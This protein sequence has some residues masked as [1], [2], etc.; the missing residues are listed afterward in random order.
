M[1]K[2]DMHMQVHMH[3]DGMKLRKLLIVIVLMFMITHGVRLF[4]NFESCK[5]GTPPTFYVGPG[6]TYTRIQDALN[7]ITADGYRIF[8]YNGTYYESLII[9]YQIDLFGED[10]GNTIIDGNGSNTVITVN[11]NNVNIS[12]FTIKNRNASVNSSLIHINGD[13]S[14]ITD[15]ILSKGYHGVLL[16]NSNNHLIYDNIIRDNA[17]DGIRLNQSNDNVNISYNTILRNKNGITSYSSQ[18]NRIYNNEIMNNNQNGI[19]LNRTCQNNIIIDN[20]ASKNG[21][22]GIYLNDYSNHQTITS[23]EIYYNNN[24]GLVL[25]N[26]STNY[27]IND[28]K[29]IGNM[30][31]GMMIIGSTNNISGNIISSNRK[32][33]LYLSADDNNT[34]YQN[35]ISFN[36]IAG[37]R[38]YNTTHDIIRNNE[39]FNNGAYGAYL[40]FFTMNNLIYNNYFHDNI[41]N[42]IDKSL[43]HNKWNVTKITKLNIIGGP[44]ICGNYWDDYDEISEDA[45]DNDTDG[46]AD[47]PYM[48]YGLNIDSGPL[49]DTIRPSIESVSISP[50]IQ[51]LGKLT[52]LSVVVTDNTKVK[53]VYLNIIDPNGLG[54][55]LSITQ[56]KTGDTYFYNTRFSP[57]GNYTV[58]ITAKDSRNW[59]HSSKYNFSI[60]PGNPPTIVDHSPTSGQPSAKFIFNTTVTS[61]DA[62]PSDLRV[63]V[64]W[65]HGDKGGNVSLVNT[66]GSYFI[67]TIVLA[68]SIAN[69]TYHFYATDQWGNDVQTENKKVKINDITPPVILI[70]QHGPS[71]EDLPNSYTFSA[72]ITD[73]SAVSSVTIEYWYTNHSK[74]KVSMDAMGNNSY[75]KVII[76]EENPEKIFCIINAS[77]IAGNTKDTKNPVACQY[78]PY[79]GMV[80]QEIKLNGTGS[81]DLDGTISNYSWN[82]GD[83]TTGRGSTVTHTY[84]SNGNY[85]VTLTVIDNDGNNGT[86]KTSIHIISFVQHKI[87]N[88][89]L[90]LINSLY[91]I[92]LTEQVFCYD[93]DGNGIED[94]FVDPNRILTAV[95][96]RP[97]NLNGDIAFLLSI[98]NDSIPEF[99]WDTTNDLVFSISHD[100]GVVTNLIVDDPHQQAVMYV[101]VNKAQWIYFEVKD[102]YPGSP[103]MITSRARTLSSD[104]F[105]REQQKIYVFDDPET[106]YQF[107]YDSIFPP[108]TA[109]FSP[110][111]G[112]VINGDNPTI[113]ITYN[114][115]VTIISATFNA[116][117]IKSEL[118]SVDNRNFTFT[119][120]GY[121][122]N[123]SYALEID[124]Q[125]LQGT[126]YLSSTVVYF[127]LAYELPPQKSFL[128]KNGV[129]ILLGGF[130]GALGALLMFFKVKNVTVDGFVYLKNRKIIPFFK[131]I[132]IGPIS[133]RIPDK[134]LSKAEFYVDGQLKDETTTF[135]A[136]WQWNESAFMKHTLE[137]KVY[138]SEGNNVSSGEMEFF[139]F[140]FSKK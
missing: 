82:F 65:T 26:C 91:H 99:F 128:E 23:N 80:L 125:A 106:E 74:M 8:V 70:K 89:Q 31:Y 52:N 11:A 110:P 123:G 42:A 24:S 101:T 16:D 53:G 28:N 122:K 133:V 40:D 33:G 105:W 139:I 27:Y 22:H 61:K 113:R 18:R 137:T 120:A 67:A 79:T 118:L 63:Y 6:E 50:N 10:R 37:I 21:N 5:A 57:T 17:G 29:V 136:L 51:I 104:Q 55:N 98:G 32:D 77:D 19:F 76:P 30:N 59:E 36:T 1:T 102:Q 135:P 93:S 129:W 140:N 45:I 81:F 86:N 132:I 39:I 60:R 95:H 44:K 96:S 126:G 41:R 64:V 115:P 25:E 58:N 43:N 87:P 71:F 78:S 47:S 109:L 108:V 46:I 35:R 111:D 3:Q 138:D 84:T 15:N 124:A 49:L 112:G 100:I 73:D 75:Q 7:N 2:R 12:H 13:H 14:I 117:N 66:R 130:L 4:S 69:M 62:I 103:V 121:L 68:A 72:T 90:D 127:Y 134:R 20:N 107:T 131:S 116:S 92:S 119:P 88:D 56:N 114:V 34:L 9:T 83:G 94:T 38:L 85:T 48:I 54:S 97:V